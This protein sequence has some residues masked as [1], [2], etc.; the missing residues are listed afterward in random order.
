M[1]NFV[2]SK[3]F[4]CYFSFFFFPDTRFVIYTEFFRNEKQV[5][6]PLLTV[7]HNPSAVRNLFRQQENRYDIQP[8]HDACACITNGPDGFCIDQRTGKRSC[9]K[10]PPAYPDCNPAVFQQISDIGLCLIAI[11]HQ[12]S[13]NKKNNNDGKQLAK[14]GVITG[15]QC[16]LCPLDPIFQTRYLIYNQTSICCRY[17]GSTA[18]TGFI[19]VNTSFYAPGYR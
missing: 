2:E 8:C 6:F 19:R 10:N 18:Y 12:R 15:Y 5:L 3:H 16:M 4:L 9:N 13:K 11:A 17:N 1:W 7:L 14:P